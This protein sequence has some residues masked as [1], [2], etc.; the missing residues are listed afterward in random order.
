M[1]KA[2]DRKIHSK[3]PDCSFKTVA[4]KDIPIQNVHRWGIKTLSDI[5]SSG[6]HAISAISCGHHRNLRIENCGRVHIVREMSD[7]IKVQIEDT[8]PIMHAMV[9]SKNENNSNF[10]LR[11]DYYPT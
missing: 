1:P 9:M 4:S 3:K 11:L 10:N 2:T 8:L 6:A 5:N 7:G